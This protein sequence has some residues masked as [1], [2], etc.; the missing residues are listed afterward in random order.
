MAQKRAMD[1]ALEGCGERAKGNR[2]S[3]DLFHAVRETSLRMTNF[4][5]IKKQRRLGMSRRCFCFEGRFRS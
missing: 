4:W 5:R 2:R 3:F 1:G